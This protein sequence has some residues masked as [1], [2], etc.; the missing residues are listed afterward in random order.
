M[1]RVG[2]M[3]LVIQSLS[4]ASP[5]I[6]DSIVPIRPGTF[7]SPFRPSLPRTSDPSFLPFDSSHLYQIPSFTKYPTTSNTKAINVSQPRI[8][9][10]SR[11]IQLPKRKSPGRE[12]AGGARGEGVFGGRA[13]A[14]AAAVASI[15]PEGLGTMRWRWYFDC[16]VGFW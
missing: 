4:Q 9:R 6:H 1:L 7:T 12:G 3:V 5:S 10:Q 8:L 11:P 15:V 2:V 14:L 13:R 16:T